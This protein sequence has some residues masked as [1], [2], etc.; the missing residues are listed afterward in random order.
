MTVA[1][2]A[3]KSIL[4]ERSSA[5]QVHGW[6]KVVTALPAFKFLTLK[7]CIDGIELSWATYSM[8]LGVFFTSSGLSPTGPAF[9]KEK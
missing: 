7:F 1:S 8:F 2:A 3:H 4:A 5:T 6:G 9:Q